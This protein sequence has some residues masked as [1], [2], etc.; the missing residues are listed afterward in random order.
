MSDA[1]MEKRKK[2]V[3]SNKILLYV[4][5]TKDEPQCGFSATAVQVFKTLG[6]PFEVVNVLA[7]PELYDRLEE[8]SGWPTFPQ[9]F[10]GGKLIGGCDITVEMH[11]SGELQKLV[12][13]TFAQK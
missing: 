13:E 11:E 9:V 4:K 12:D 3:E 7:D 1:F 5:G 10:V 8:F 2:E 6:K